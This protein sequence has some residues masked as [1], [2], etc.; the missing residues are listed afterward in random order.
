MDDKLKNLRER[1]ILQSYTDREIDLCFMKCMV[2]DDSTID[3][4]VKSTKTTYWKATRRMCFITMITFSSITLLLCLILLSNA[5]LRAQ[6]LRLGHNYM[7]PVMR[8]VRYLALP[9]ISRVHLSGIHCS[10]NLPNINIDLL[11]SHS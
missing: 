10:E 4:I 9:F 5:E 7:Y 2:N 8:T 6:A 1:G 11:Y 3:R